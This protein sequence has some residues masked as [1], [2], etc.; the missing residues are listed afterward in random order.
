MEDAMSASGLEVFDKTLQTTHIWLDEIMK[1]VGPDRH[2]AWHVLGAVLR[3]LRDRVPIGLAAHLGAQLPL[4]VRGLYYDQWSPSDKP[5]ELRNG[6]E[7][8]KHVSE[9]LHDTRPVNVV[10]AVKVVFT[11]I[12]AHVPEG[13]VRK[14][15]DS[16]PKDVRAMWPEDEPGGDTEYGTLKRAAGGR[17]T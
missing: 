5:L 3:T 14:I 6:E 13:Q 8:L 11:T 12:S 9:Q 7:F 2:V 15:R 17:G 4:L 16:L 1:K 10:D